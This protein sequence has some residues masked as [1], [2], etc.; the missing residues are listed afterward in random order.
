MTR[1]AHPLE[2]R[3]GY[4]FG[5]PALLKQALTHRSAGPLHN[6]RLECLGDAVLG[7]VITQRLYQQFPDIPEGDL[8]RLRARLVRRET[9]AA[10]AR[11]LELGNLI[12]LGAGEKNTGG[13][14]RDS[15]LADALEAV[16]GALYLDGGLGVAETQVLA[17][18]GE[19]LDRWGDTPPDTRDA[20]S[21]L[22]EFLQSRGHD[23]P[24]YEVVAMSGKAHAR[25]FRV[26]CQVQGLPDATTGEGS[27][28]RAAEQSAASLALKA[29]GQPA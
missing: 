19:R 7:L 27:S 1:K 10:V 21:R 26:S 12:K 13:S 2:A 23:L 6:E 4:S 28:R 14:R 22:Q 8:S 16:I 17:L 20:K 18:L 9:L 25:Q 11:S 15:I 24:V 5:K 29:L 3:L